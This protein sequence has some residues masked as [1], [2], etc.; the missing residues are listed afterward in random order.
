MESFDRRYVHTVLLSCALTS[1]V[2]VGLL[3][4]LRIEAVPTLLLPVIVAAVPLFAKSGRFA[5]AADLSAAALV[6]VFVILGS[7]SIGMYY[8]P[9]AVLLLLAGL[10]A[11]P[12]RGRG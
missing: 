8:V 1:T 7:F 2:A 5:R 10:A 3:V 9:A 12:S 4:A 6:L 11:P